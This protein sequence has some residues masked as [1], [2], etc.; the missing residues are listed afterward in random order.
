LP[1]IAIH[2]LA[3][4]YFKNANELLGEM[5]K[6]D[7]LNQGSR[8]FMIISLG[9]M[10]DI[11][12]AE[13]E[14]KRAKA[15]LGNKF[16]SNS[17]AITCIRLATKDTLSRDEIAYSNPVFHTIKEYIDSPKICVA[18]LRR[19]Y[20]NEVD[21]S[22]VSLHGILLGAAYFG[23]HEFA[24][25]VLEKTISINADDILFFWLP[26]FHEVRQTP[27]F[28]ALVKRMGLVDYW[29]RFGWPDICR[30]LDNGDFMCD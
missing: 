27:R 3:V 11:Q 24:V 29:N 12:R 25:T 2:Y 19:L 23:D 21:L 26:V 1:V 20:F 4:G 10:G 7:P 14:N 30:P 13:E 8:S 22:P 16:D 28:K 5:L 17:P 18:E 15:L 6:N 9:L